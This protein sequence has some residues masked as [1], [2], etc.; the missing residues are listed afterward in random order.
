MTPLRIFIVDDDADVADSLADVLELSGHEVTTAYGSSEAVEKFH[1]QDFDLV[2]MDVMMPGMNGVE[3]FI[4]IKKF[5]PDAKVVM[6]T[7][8][9]VQNLL[10]QAIEE[11]AAGVLHKPVAVEDILTMLEN[12]EP[13]AERKALVLVADHDEAFRAE[14]QRLIVD[15]GYRV[16][17]AKT[18]EEALDLV[19]TL[20]VDVLILDLELPVSDGL[21]VYCE[22]KRTGTNVPT[23][24]VASG[25]GKPED[26]AVPLKDPAVSGVLF[27]PVDPAVLL[28]SLDKLAHTND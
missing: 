28:N 4:E 19:N 8:F 7:G 15:K 24:V 5:K 20:D 3:S 13:S 14:I 21:E 22:M 1:E 27:K 6:M 17:S 12:Q 9:S 18:G 2:F 11:G 26:S 10:D 23:L 25:P 16:R